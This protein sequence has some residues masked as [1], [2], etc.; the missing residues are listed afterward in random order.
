MKKNKFIRIIPKLDIKN[1]QLIKGINLEGLRVL[2]DPYDFAYDY[3]KDLADEICYIDNVATLYGTNNL[4]KFITRTAKNLFIPLTVGGGIK[5]IADIDNALKSGADKV[6]INSAAINDKNFIRESSRIYGSSTIV[7]LIEVIKIGK[8]YFISKS[9]GRDLV[10]INPLDWALQVEDFGA[11]EIFLTVVNKEGLGTGFDIDIIKKISKK[12]RIPLIAHGGAGKKEH[13][14]DLLKKT[15]VSG[16]S[17]ASFFHY[18]IV[19]KF[20]YKKKGYGNFNFLDNINEYN[21]DL[22]QNQI[23][24][25]KKYLVKHNIEVR[26]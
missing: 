20:I 7:S 10:N 3:Y 6:S 22:I 9:N 1:G 5:K 25:L 19:K 8:N 4:S 2:G 24:K 11:G 21:L 18:N 26:L 15:N 14:L 23:T 12:V 16:V 13:I 17:I